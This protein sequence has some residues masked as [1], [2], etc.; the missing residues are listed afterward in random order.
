MGKDLMKEFECFDPD[1]K[2]KFRFRLREVDE[3][4]AHYE[5]GWVKSKGE[6]LIW[7]HLDTEVASAL[8]NKGREIEREERLREDVRSMVEHMKEH[9]YCEATV[10]DVSSCFKITEEKAQSILDEISRVKDA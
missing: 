7:N 5:Y 2:L 9:L 8:L 3:L 6:V 10:Q 1:S 4:D